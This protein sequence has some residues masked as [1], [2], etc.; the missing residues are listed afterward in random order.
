LKNL[1]VYSLPIFILCSCANHGQLTYVVKLPKDLKE[2]SG[3][4]A[5]TENTAW[6][7]EDS[8]NSYN[9]YKIN[10]DGEILKTL[11]V[12]NAKNKDW[13]DLAKDDEGNLYI[14]DFGNNENR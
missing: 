10:F 5:Y 7:I 8:G 12:K 4:V 3:L 1:S 13:E 11:E 9:I 2:N 6:G 14:G